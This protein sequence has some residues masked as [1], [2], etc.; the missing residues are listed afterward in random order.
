MSETKRTPISDLGEFGLIDRI[1][2]DIKIENTSTEKGVGDDAAVLAYGSKKTVVSTDLLLEGIHF[3]LVY[4]PLKHLGYKAAVVNFSDIY[5]MNAE[6]KQLLVA[7]GV[8][9]RFSV[10]DIDELYSGIRMACEAYGVDLVG[11]D[12]SASMTGLTISATAIGEGEEGKLA[13]RNGAKPKEL[14]CL[15]GNLGAAYMGLQLLEREKK[16]FAGN[17]KVQPMLDGYSYVL[18]RQLKPEARKDTIKRLKE[19]GIVPTSMIDI[20][21]GLASDLVHILRASGTGAEIDTDA[22]PT[23]AS[24]EL[25]VTGG[26]DYKLLFTLAPDDYARLSD[27]YR[28][29]FGMPLHPVGRIVTGPPT[30]QWLE[31]GRPVAKEW[32]GF[33]HF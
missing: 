26:E 32:R 11:G 30:I 17:D 29:H 6:P 4:T 1:T 15:T 28:A 14:I 20:S 3:D 5:A 8:S 10:E 21:D 9:G 33:V 31:G 19:N 16:V 27:N 13:Y 24:L 2:K 23:T 12:T 22:I 7:I 18:G 25:A